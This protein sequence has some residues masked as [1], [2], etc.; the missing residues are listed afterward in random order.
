MNNTGIKKQLNNAIEKWLKS[1]INQLCKINNISKNKFYEIL[2]INKFF[3]N[4]IAEQDLFEITNYEIPADEA[5]FILIHNILKYLI[6]LKKSIIVSGGCITSMYLNEE[7]NDYDI[8]FKDKNI[9]NSILQFYIKEFNNKNNTK[10]QYD[11]T[12]NK[13]FKFKK[14]K[15]EHLDKSE[16]YKDLDKYVEMSDAIVSKYVISNNEN[17][18]DPICITPNAISLTNNVQL[19]IRFYGEPEEIIKNFDFIHTNNYFDYDKNMLHTCK[20]SIESILT[21]TLKYNGSRFP[22]CSL[23]RSRKFINRG[24]FI[25]AGEYLKIAFQINK[26]N[27]NDINILREQLIGVDAK[28]FILFLEKLKNVKDINEINLFDLLDTIFEE[29]GDED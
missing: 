24:W 12:L 27:L 1:Y 17:I 3:N 9:I 26:L 8:Y 5:D 11:S 16:I 25:S 2:N 23:I 19:V 7:V 21:K 6:E 29:I 15:Y 20:E 4:F 22:I 13:I 18:Y 14:D 28:Y 10:W